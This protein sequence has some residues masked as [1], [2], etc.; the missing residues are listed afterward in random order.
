MPTQGPARLLL[1]WLDSNQHRAYPLDESTS[2]GNSVIPFPL[3]VDALFTV[4]A[5]VDRTRLFINKLVVGDTSLR[6]YLSGYVNDVL[7]DF[8]SVADIP[9]SSTQGTE[10]SVDV[11]TVEYSVSGSLVIGNIESVQELQA[12]TSLAIS[13]GLIFP[14]CVR[15]ESIGLTGIEVD[16]VIYSGVVTL[17]AGAGVSFSVTESGGSVTIAINAV[18]YTVPSV[19]TQ[20]TS[21]EELLDE[22]ISMFG[23]PVRSINNI[24]TDETG[25]ISIVEGGNSSGSEDEGGSPA[26][27]TVTAAGQGALTISLTNDTTVTQCNDDLTVTVDTLM[28]GV[29]NLNDRIAEINDAITA[30]DK[31]NNN[32]AIQLS[33]Y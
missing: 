2:G 17:S 31:A 5:N 10:I 24:T 9:L 7:I 11:A 27:V 29:A 26:Y 4:S 18:N 28:S 15:E 22:A 14:G 25:N 19:N 21:D 16:G 23:Y 12:V 30:I 1:E 3:F 6:V 20:I 33:R 32:I 13:S 8:G